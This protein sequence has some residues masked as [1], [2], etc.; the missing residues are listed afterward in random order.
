[1]L[2]LQLWRPL[3]NLKVMLWLDEMV[4]MIKCLFSD[5]LA[6]Q[7]TTL[8]VAIMVV[9]IPICIVVSYDFTILLQ[10]TD[11]YRDVILIW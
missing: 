1:M 10:L 2:N 6:P 7:P 8:T 9:S 5:I 4:T 3:L 11:T